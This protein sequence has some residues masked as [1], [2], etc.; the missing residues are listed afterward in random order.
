MILVPGIGFDASIFS[1]FMAANINKYTMYAVTA[2][3]YGET[4][5]P[6][7]PAT[8]TSYGKQYWNKGFIKGIIKLIE[9]EKLEKPIV[10]GHF[11]QGAQVALR[12]AID[13]PDK[14]SGTAGI[15]VNLE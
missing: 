6:P 10:V 14:T 1:D 11:T 9:K 13:Y 7:M 15:L 12:I 4:N 8:D 5:A 3:G 2:P